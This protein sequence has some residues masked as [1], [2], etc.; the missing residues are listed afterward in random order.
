MVFPKEDIVLMRS[1]YK[2]GYITGSTPWY[3]AKKHLISQSKCYKLVKI[4]WTLIFVHT[5]AAIFLNYYKIDKITN[6]KIDSGLNANKIFVFLH[7]TTMVL[8]VIPVLSDIWLKET[9]WHT[10]ILRFENLYEELKRKNHCNN[11]LLPTLP[12]ILLFLYGNMCLL[13]VNLN[14][15]E[16][17]LENV[18]TI[19]V[20]NLGILNLIVNSFIVSILAFCI[21][22][23]YKDL[24]SYLRNMLL[25]PKKSV[26][27]VTLDEYMCAMKIR[28]LGEMYKS[29]KYIVDTFNSLYSGKL[30]I[31]LLFI[32]FDI[33]KGARYVLTYTYSPL[34][35]QFYVIYTIVSNF[36]SVSV[37]KL[38]T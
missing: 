32:F 27:L 1:V 13:F 3:N 15:F 19:I 21:K 28:E 16:Y 2:I 17:N 34:I 11:T 25:L 37:Y 10:L 18:F 29:L 31:M 9:A 7:I 33:I 38:N 20:N 4:A 12:L 5:C 35:S 8:S 23:R 30:E 36:V 6:A 22:C 14:I 24:N 26:A